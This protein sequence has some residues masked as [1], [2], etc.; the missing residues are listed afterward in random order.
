M[1]FE[2]FERVSSKLD[3]AAT[4]KG[5]VD[6][7][8][9]RKGKKPEMRMEASSAGELYPELD[10]QDD[11]QQQPP[12]QEKPAAAEAKFVYLTAPNA[13]RSEQAIKNRISALK[14]GQRL[15]VELLVNGKIQKAVMTR[16]TSGAL[17]INGAPA[18]GTVRLAV[19]DAEAAQWR[20]KQGM[21]VQT[22]NKS[23]IRTTLAAA[24]ESLDLSEAKLTK[25]HFNSLAGVISALDLSGG[26]RKK[27][28]TAL[29]EWCADLNPDFDAD[30]F[31]DAV[32]K[33]D[34]DD[35]DDEVEDKD[36]DDAED[37][38]TPT[39]G[40]E[41]KTA[42]KP[43]RPAVAVGESMAAVAAMMINRKH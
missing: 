3:P 5:L 35:S 16:D 38:E 9:S 29:A 20:K 7:F 34:D 15:E 23:M 39:D 2:T 42:E 10:E 33:S 26:D 21:A 14:D 30:R 36:K 22:E 28:A 17:L 8:S 1:G 41:E 43:K 12:A 19:L 18:A 31:M 4:R 37:A 6:L 25:Q 24:V 11:A 27:V 32:M 40:E 13:Y